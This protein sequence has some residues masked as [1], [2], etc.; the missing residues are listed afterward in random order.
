MKRV[1]LITGA[2]SGTGR[3]AAL[4]LA[5]NSHAIGALWHSVDELTDTVGNIKECGHDAIMLNSDI[6][7]EKE[8]WTVI[9][10]VAECDDRIDVVVTNA[11]INGAWAPIDDL[12]LEEWNKTSS[13]NLTRAFPTIAADFPLLKASGGGSIIV[14]SSING[15]RTFATP[16]ATACTTTTAGQ[17][18][19]VQQLTLEV[20]RYHIGI[21]AVRTGETHTTMEA[22]TSLRQED[23]TAIPVIWL[24]GQVAI[25]EGRPG[26]SE[27]V[28][29]LITFLAAEKARHIIRSP[30]LVDSG[31]GLLR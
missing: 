3:A 9:A 17:I 2:E 10:A 20:A 31:Q 5:A 14:V 4:L 22:N 11:G 26:R 1:A 29:E 13:V 25:T 18:A 7:G 21:I 16:G 28:A 15:T 30:I 24:D 12:S 8:M 27:D 19:M 23:Q 6:S